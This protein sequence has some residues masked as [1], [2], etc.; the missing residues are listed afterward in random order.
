MQSKMCKVRS[1]KSDAQCHLAQMTDLTAHRC[2]SGAAFRE[3]PINEL[4]MSNLCVLLAVTLIAANSTDQVLTEAFRERKVEVLSAQHGDLVKAC[5]QDTSAAQ[6]CYNAS[7][8]SYLL[9]LQ[10]MQ[11]DSD[12]AAQSLQQCGRFAATAGSNAAFKPESDA[13]LTGCFGLSI[14]MNPAKGMSLGP[15]SA[16]MLQQALAVAPTSPRVHY[17]AAMRLF[18]TPAIWGGDA[19]QALEHA[20]RALALFDESKSAPTELS[21]G[22]A[23]VAHLLKQIKQKD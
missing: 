15:K 11:G 9:A 5:E 14:A 20:E 4:V 19:K 8:A 12:L 16:E 17:F 18:R 23:E 10:N 2:G 21:W 13:L 3:Y 6:T 7:L 1:A 22:K